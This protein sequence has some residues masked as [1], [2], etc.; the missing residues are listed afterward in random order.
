MRPYT[1]DDPEPHGSRNLARYSRDLP[2]TV[3]GRKVRR[4]GI[5]ALRAEFADCTRCTWVDA[6]DARVSRIRTAYRRKR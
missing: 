2:D 4:F 1:L 6:R 3:K 5:H